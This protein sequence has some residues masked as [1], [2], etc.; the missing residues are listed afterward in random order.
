MILLAAHTDTVFN[1]PKIGY[2]DGQHVGLLD[3]FIGVLVTYLSLYQHESMR[4]YETEGRLRIYHNRGEEYGHLTEPPALNPETDVAV[5]VDVCSSDAYEG[6]DVSFE[7]VSNLPDLEDVIAE[8]QR[9]G[10]R[11]R[12]KPY[13]GEPNDNDEAFS[14]VARGIP[15]FSFTIPIQ[16]IDH[17]WHR[18]Q[19]DNTIHS[20]V[21]AKAALIL[22]RTVLHLLPD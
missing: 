3:N 5:V 11:I 7:N 16:A 18:I 6:Y 14:W 17:N 10:F 8:L 19:C 20:D 4:R 15:A 1:N 2:A 9:E 12:Y 13:T 21:V 22:T